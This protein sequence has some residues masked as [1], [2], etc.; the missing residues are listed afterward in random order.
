MRGK[1]Y[2]KFL[3]LVLAMNSFNV[4]GQSDLETANNLFK[5]YQYVNAIPYYESS[6]EKKE[7]TF[8]LERLG[9]CYRMIGNS[10]KAESYYEK[11]L[12]HRDFNIETKFNYA[13]VLRNNEKYEEAQKYFQEYLAAN[14]SKKKIVSPFIEACLCN[15]S[16]GSSISFFLPRQGRLD[17]LN[18]ED[19]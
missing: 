10:K 8:V 18:P 1:S 12:Q 2:L 19:D 16:E 11:A 3:V 17:G 15:Q 14:P 5:S 6:I 4:F 9:D 7:I 13:Q